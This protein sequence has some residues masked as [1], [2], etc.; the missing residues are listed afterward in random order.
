MSHA[1]PEHRE[2]ASTVLLIAAVASSAS[3]LLAM[4]AAGALH[5]LAQ[6]PT[7]LFSFFL[8]TLVLQLV[9]VDVPGGGAVSFASVGVLATGFTFGAG[10]AMA[11]AIFIAAARAVTARGKLHRAIFDAAALAVSAGLGSALYAVAAPS[12]AATLG[13][14]AGAF[15]AGAAYAAINIVLLSFAMAFSEGSSALAVWRSRF[16]WMTPYSLATG[17]LA[18]ALELAYEKVGLAGV[19]AFALPPALMMVSVR[20]YVAKTRNA[21]EETRQANESLR[22][23][24]AELAARNDDLHAL[25]EF[26]ANLAAKTHDRTDLIRYVEDTLSRMTRGSAR[27]R[28]GPGSGGHALVSGGRQIGTLSLLA[29]EG[30]DRARWERLRDV[31]LPHLATAIESSDLVEQIRKTHLATIAALSRTM[32]A[33]DYY[34]SGHTERVSKIAVALGTRLG[35]D[36]ADLDAIEIGALLHDIGKIGIPERILQK[37]GKLD[38]EEWQVMREHPLIS[39][40][41]LSEVELPEIVRQIVRS[42]HERLDGAGYPDQLAGD[43]VPLP[44]RIV[45]VA[46]AFDAITSDRP[47]RSGRTI[48]AAL[49]ELRANAGTQFCPRVVQA[50]E[51]IAVEQPALLEKQTLRAVKVA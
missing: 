38:D 18:F 45:L 41:I 51:Q 49:D 39:D 16:G 35:Y 50:L 34:T 1:Y 19:L 48:P 46:D 8:V 12:S 29:E 22:V 43:D 20:Q 11:V 42:S 3:A 17:P 47:Y 13:R 6:A 26:A 14:F 25:F 9:A 15:A 5:S 36:G 10:V 33:K 2:S 24:N 30:F 27:I 40:Y 32:E 23:A 7:E 4:T 31:F 21:V 37:P 28:V 44:A